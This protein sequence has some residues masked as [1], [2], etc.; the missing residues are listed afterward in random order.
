LARSKSIVSQG[1]P[2]LHKYAISTQKT[3]TNLYPG[4]RWC[5]HESSRART[6]V[7]GAVTNRLEQAFGCHSNTRSRYEG[8]MAQG[9]RRRQAKP[10]DT[11]I[12]DKPAGTQA[13]RHADGVCAHDGAVR[14]S[15]AVAA[16]DPWHEPA[17][18][19]HW[20]ADSPGQAALSGSAGQCTG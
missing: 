8:T 9:R 19:D 2:V 1:G 15:V 14:L 7:R 5:P 16:L 10:D 6:P 17:V 20:R 4:C 18:S 13:S 12:L 11:R 3:L